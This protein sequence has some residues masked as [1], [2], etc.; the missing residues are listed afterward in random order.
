M[1]VKLV[2]DER[3]NIKTYSAYRGSLLVC[4]L[5]TRYGFSTREISLYHHINSQNDSW[6]GDIIEFGEWRDL[7]TD[8]IEQCKEF[9]KEK[10]YL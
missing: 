10:G 5:E 9:L 1:G 7:D 3:T 8:E 6:R 4:S 2:L